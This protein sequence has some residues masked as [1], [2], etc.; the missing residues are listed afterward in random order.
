MGVREQYEER[1]KQWARF[2]RWESGQPPVERSAADI[3]ADLG[4]VLDWVPR[5]ARA[6]DPDPQKLGIQA[7]RRA[8]EH[9]GRVR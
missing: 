2:N 4:T 3:V 7:M 5:E 1:R 6:D 9:L 8:L